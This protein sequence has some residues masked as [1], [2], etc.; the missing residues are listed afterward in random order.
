MRKNKHQEKL[1]QN[2][3]RVK[4]QSRNNDWSVQA[5]KTKIRAQEVPQI[6]K[7]PSA[8]T[9]RKSRNANVSNLVI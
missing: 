3:T 5:T 2:K 8:T 4:Q 9:C 6:E 1:S 7:A